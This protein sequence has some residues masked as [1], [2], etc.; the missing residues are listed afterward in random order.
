M[1]PA[2]LLHPQNASKSL[3]A[4]ALSQT[5]LGELS[6]LSRHPRWGREEREEKERG[7]KEEE[8]RA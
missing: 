2:S 5:T 3:A 7:Y 8:G 1:P 6:V 4:G